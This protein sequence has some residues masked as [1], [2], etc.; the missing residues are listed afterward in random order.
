MGRYPKGFRKMSVVRLKG[1]DNIVELSE[2][3]GIHRR[4]L[5]KWRDQMEPIEDGDGHR[6]TLANVR[7]S[8]S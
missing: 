4:L 2:R 5:S 1:R 7:C 8:D 6:S 3:L